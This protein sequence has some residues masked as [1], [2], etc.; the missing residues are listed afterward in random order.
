M[1]AP[2][3][4]SG[5]GQ[6]IMDRGRLRTSGRAR[7]FN[8]GL[9]RLL[10]AAKELHDLLSQRGPSMNDPDFVEEL[11]VARDQLAALSRLYRDKASESRF[12][13]SIDITTLLS[14]P[15]G[16]SEYSSAKNIICI[17]NLGE[18]SCS[19]LSLRAHEAGRVPFE[20]LSQL[21]VSSFPLD[22]APAELFDRNDWKEAT[23]ALAV[24]V[25]TQLAIS[26]LQAADGA[27]GSPQKVILDVFCADEI[28]ESGQDVR[29]ILANSS[30]FKSLP[31]WDPALFSHPELDV[32][33][34]RHWYVA[35]CKNML[36]LLGAGGGTV[37]AQVLDQMAKDFP[38]GKLVT[39]LQAWIDETTSDLFETSLESG[40]RRD[41]QLSH[42]QVEFGRSGVSH[43]GPAPASQ[44][45]VVSDV[46][47]S[48]IRDFVSVRDSS[49]PPATQPRPQ[50]GGDSSAAIAGPSQGQGPSRKRGR[51]ESDAGSSQDDDSD[52]FQV[53]RR[54]AIPDSQL[55]PP[56]PRPAPVRRP[57]GFFTRRPKRVRIEG[58][59]PVDPRLTGP[60]PPSAGPD[61][62]AAAR[63]SPAPSPTLAVI[64]AS[65]GR[66]S[67]LP[68]DDSRY[69]SNTPM[70]DVEWLSQQS[71]A[72]SLEARQRNPKTPQK[73]ISW[74][75]HDCTLLITAIRD[76]EARWSKI[77]AQIKSG[78]LQ[79]D[80]ERDQQALRDKA[81]LLKVDMLKY[82]FSSLFLLFP[83]QFLSRSNTNA[84][85]SFFFSGPTSSCLLA[86]TMWFWAAR[87]ARRS[88]T[89][90]ETL[91]VGRPTWRTASLS[92][93]CCPTTICQRRASWWLQACR[94]RSSSSSRRRSRHKR[95]PRSGP[96]PSLWPLV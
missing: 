14:H 35:R 74:S 18:F 25:R 16:S 95:S 61:Q 28:I 5:I 42:A 66:G 2:E 77:A 84:F 36:R 17:A 6:R 51:A 26:K 96:K 13:S 8:K 43:F 29:A 91:S 58:D 81:R 92:T 88:R 34:I 67:A 53:D 87:N 80:H 27:Q 62:V 21:D 3:S 65:T 59:V 20:L 4:P 68:S 19:L 46:S 41:P 9:P 76:Q 44:E 79:F 40:V 31:G 69:S 90:A 85:F 24:D 70:P 49:L 33:Q 52:A 39:S 32:D 11:E 64:N 56:P 1:D 86:L 93:R 12:I 63:P 82:V 10:D 73:R 37:T 57:P 45:S 60:P 83:S 54:G 94:P 89:W 48:E 78:E 30:R 50:P 23:I 22:F 38:P 72:V 71:K 47:V 55:M 7:A 75:T 15:P